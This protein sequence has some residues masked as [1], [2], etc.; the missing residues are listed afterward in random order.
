MG[1]A[2][3]KE[4][5]PRR[6]DYLQQYS[7][8]AEVATERQA[9][10]DDRHGE[11][12]QGDVDNFESVLSTDWHPF[13]DVRGVKYYHNFFTTERMRQS[14][15]RVP[16]ESDPGVP[17]DNTIKEMQDK[18]PEVP[19]DGFNALRSEIPAADLA[20]E[21]QDKNGDKRNLK[22]PYRAHMPCD[23]EAAAVNEF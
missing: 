17:D 10:L 16:N 15:R 9:M 14:P 5:Q 7:R 13:Y 12:K 3:G 1:P 19:L 18:V 11:K 4:N 2:D 23:P 6:I 22:A 21:D 20:A 8:Y